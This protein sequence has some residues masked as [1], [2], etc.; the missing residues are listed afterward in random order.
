MIDGDNKRPPVSNIIWLQLISPIGQQSVY[1]RAYR[2][3]RSFE[4][5]I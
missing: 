1:S 2:R 4:S 3:I 5:N